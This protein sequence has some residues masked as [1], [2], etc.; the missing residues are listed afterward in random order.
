MRISLTDR[1]ADL[2][3]VLWDRG[4]STVAEVRE[5]LK[6][7]RAYTT[8]LSLL[9]TLEG[10][11]LVRHEENGRAHRYVATVERDAAR[12]SALHQLARKF[13]QG[14]AALLLSHL[15]SDESLTDEDIKRLTRLLAQ[16]RRKERR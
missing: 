11:G 13:F 1:E 9:R 6:D 3:V 16:R 7:D 4:P 8:V 14:S 12:R 2:M 10:K 15:A 5:H